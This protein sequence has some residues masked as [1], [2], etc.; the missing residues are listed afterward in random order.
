MEKY[1]VLII[2]SNRLYDYIDNTADGVKF[3]N[4]NKTD[5]DNLIIMSMEQDF[6]V[7]VQ[8]YEEEE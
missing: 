2:S 4:I 7:V 5:L 6:T 8:K 3:K 1:D